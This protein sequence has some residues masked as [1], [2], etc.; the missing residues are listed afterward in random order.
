MN[1]RRFAVVPLVLVLL[2]TLVVPH[3]HV[4]RVVGHREEGV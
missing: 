2:V 3:P 1:C 4:P